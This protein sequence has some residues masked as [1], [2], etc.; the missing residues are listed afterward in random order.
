MTKATYHFPRDFLW[1]TATASYQVEG[2]NTNSN[3][4]AW[5][6]AEKIINGQRSKLACD[7][8]GGRWQE[9][10]DLA[11]SGGQNVHRLSIEWSRVQPTPDR[12]DEEAID[13]YREILRGLNERGLT[14]MVTLHHFTE[15]LWITEIGGW[16][17]EDCLEPFKAYV[18]KIVEALKD[19]ANFWITINEPNV[20]TI[21]S[22]IL[23]DFPPGKKNLWTAAKVAVNLVRAHALAYQ[24]IHKIQPAAQVGIA[25]NYHA[26]KPKRSWS[27]FDRLAT[28]QV[29]SQ[30][31]EL[32]PSAVVDGIV[33][34]PIRN[35]RIPE[36][37]GTQDF[38][39]L[40]YYTKEYLAFDL[41]KP[42]QV[43]IQR[44]HSPQAELG[45]TAFI[46]NEPEG[47]FEALKWSCKYNLPIIV[48]ENGV[49]NADDSLR[50]RYLA[51]HIHQLWR[52]V[53]F[54]WPIK[55]YI[56]WT[57]VDNFEWERGWTQRFGL[58]E[59]DVDTQTRRKRP[60][61]DFY[62]EICVENALSSDMVVKY[63]PE[64]LAKIFP[65]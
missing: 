55:G 36:A 64:V 6:E 5:E 19:Y 56:H 44:S 42:K 13:K 48:T 14:P 12:W 45:D 60:S 31:N 23:G 25:H 9:D 18:Q 38:F 61:A 28:Y 10:L 16:E 57:L 54:N 46:A 65:Q 33:R 40:N 49:E 59:L 35:I 11:A 20:L 21:S 50:P 30:L 3:W 4:Y 7:W 58:W 22:Y 34:L 32:F 17:K 8:W 52:A 1:G 15:P 24:T 47:F 62:S 51:E 26:M 39:G 2:N 63:A 27:P 41:L 37:K 43:F 29:F 53:N